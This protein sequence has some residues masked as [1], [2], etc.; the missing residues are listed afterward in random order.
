VDIE[1]LEFRAMVL[2]IVRNFLI[3]NSFL[4]VDTPALSKA[5]IPESS[6]EVFKTEYI[7]GYGAKEKT[8]TLFLL[9]SPELYIKRLIAEHKRS[10]FQ[11][12]KCYRNCESIGRAHSPEFSML[13]YYDVG[14]DYMDLLVLTHKL[15]LYIVKALKNHP[16]LAKNSV[17]A[18]KKGFTVKTVDELFID[19]LHFSIAREY[20]REA[21]IYYAKNLQKDI[22]INFDG[23]RDSD[24]YDMIFV[25]AIE[26]NLPKDRLIVIKDYPFFVSCLAKKKDV[27]MEGDRIWSVKERWELYGGGEEMCNC[28]SEMR[29]KKEIDEY[30]N[31]EEALKRHALVM[32]KIDQDFSSMCQKMPKCSGV[33]LGLDRLLMFLTNKKTIDAVLPFS[34]S[35]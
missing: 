25:H 7:R 30:F 22:D 12:S 5:L 31:V 19:Y 17:D 24:I 18:I 8:K 20:S 28:Y 2:N 11:I 6:I 26:P 10:F 15:L 34:L 14:K 27:V 21:L 1:M 35:L 13:E 9:P 3:E 29:D 23:M 32:P 16:L 33:A 4:E